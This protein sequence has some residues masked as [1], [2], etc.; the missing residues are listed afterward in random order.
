MV[1]RRL[2]ATR[3]GSIPRWGLGA[4]RPAWYRRNGA[5]NSTRRRRR[6]EIAVSNVAVIPQ[7]QQGAL[8]AQPRQQ[9]DLSPQTFEQALT[10]ADYLAES[11]LVPKDFKGKPANCLIAMQWGAELGLKPL[12]ALQN[13]AVINGRAALWGDAV[14]ALVRNSP[15]CEFVEEWDDHETAHCKVKRKGEKEALVTFSMEDAKKAGLIGKQGP[16]TQ[17]PKRMRQMRA[18]AFALRDVFTDVLRGMAIAEEIMDIPPA[19][20][21]GAEPARTAIEGQADKQQ[22]PLYSEADFASNLPKWWDIVANGKKT[23]DDLIAM[24][25]TR[26]RFTAEQ[27]KE[28]RNPPTDVDEGHE[29]N[30]VQAAAGGITQTAVER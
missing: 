18:R 3:C 12:Q 14:L 28:I 15:V 20:A 16:W 4:Q 5:P 7:N 22:L 11:D 26:A 23:A 24:L 27:L 9:F 8:V 19:G 6:Q 21:A 29:Q 17:Y 30:D 25:Q 10:F 13:I 2:G 1:G